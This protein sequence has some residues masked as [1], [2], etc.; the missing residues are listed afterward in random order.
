MKPKSNSKSSESVAAVPLERQR[1]RRR[2]QLVEITARLIEAE[3]VE[4]V[5]LARIAELAD[6]SRALV[7]RYFSNVGELLDTVLLRFV[8]EMGDSLIPH[9]VIGVFSTAAA[10]DG[11]PQAPRRFLAQIFDVFDRVGIAGL[12]LLNSSIVAGASDEAQSIRRLAIEPYEGALKG[13][14]VGGTEV[15][16]LFG[17]LVSNAYFVVDHWQ[18]GSLTRDEAI[19]LCQ[20]SSTALL[21]AFSERARA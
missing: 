7:Y 8:E 20:L 2:S 21:R 3:G 12:V 11:D 16:L 14:G 4:A 15:E 6:C 17:M 10:A 9:D 13:L 5:T 19:D 1:D 18:R